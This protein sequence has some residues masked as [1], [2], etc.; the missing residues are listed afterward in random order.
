[1]IGRNRESI[2][3]MWYDVLFHPI[4]AMQTLSRQRCL[5][6]ALVSLL[7]GGTPFWA[8]YFTS[9]GR[10]GELAVLVMGLS[11]LLMFAVWLIGTALVHLVAAL[12]GGDGEAT[13]L[14]CALGHVGLPQLFLIPLAAFAQC[15]PEGLR[16]AVLAVGVVVLAGWTLTL[17]VLAVRECY[18][19]SSAKAILVLISP[20]LVLLI[21]C[22]FVAMLFGVSALAF[23]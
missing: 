8:V 6:R 7:A 12:S 22:L 3:E 10:G 17:E 16:T 15:L 23:I 14:L 2:W 9:V 1:M 18:H 13:G 4:T 21:G 20:L 5:G 19:F 11:V